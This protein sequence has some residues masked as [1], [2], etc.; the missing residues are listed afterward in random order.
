M[1]ASPMRSY[2]NALILI[3]AVALIPAPSAIAQSPDTE[4]A[5]PRISQLSQEE[6]RL[7]VG[8][9]ID[10][11]YLSGEDLTPEEIATL[12]APRVDYF[13][14]RGKRRDAI[15]RDKLAYF[16]RWPDRR[17]ELIAESLEVYRNS[18]A[19]QV[20]IEFE[21]QF[22]TRGRGRQ[23]SGRGVAFLTLDF[24]Q[25]GGQIVREEGRVLDRGP[26]SF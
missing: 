18:D 26:V 7:V 3:A 1:S 24:S 2:I 19:E 21:Y 12:Y 17:Y 20:D 11:F 25:P 6:L 22:E 14:D 8:R 5:D 15:V 10:G 23:S 16:R 13:G 4:E 9:F